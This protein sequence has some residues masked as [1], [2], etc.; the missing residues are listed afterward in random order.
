MSP[1]I[2]LGLIIYLCG[3]VE[4][5]ANKGKDSLLG[6]KSSLFVKHLCLHCISHYFTCLDFLMVTC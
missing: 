6:V 3:V 2:I 5:G 1:K 4:V